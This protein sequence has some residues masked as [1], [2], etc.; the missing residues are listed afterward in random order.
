VRIS[1]PALILRWAAAL[2]GA[3]YVA[4]VLVRWHELVTNNN[5][6]T[7]AV[8]KMVVAER[9]RGSGP[10][11][12]PHYGEWTTLWWMLATR[13]LSW[14]H[15][16]WAVSGYAWILAGAAVLA[17]ATWR[18]A[19]AWAGLTAAAAM[20]VVGPFAI[21]SYIA[22]TGAHTTSTVA[23]IVLGALYSCAR[24]A[25]C[26]RLPG[27][28]SPACARRRTRSSGSAAFCRSRLPLRCSGG[29]GRSPFERAPS[30]SRLSSPEW[31][32]TR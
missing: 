22:T 16:L 6:D 24:R 23:A 5:W 20:L 4:Y 9:L 17:W 30:S 2:A 28:C 12:I 15:D 26:L 29:K 7:D 10:V 14:H 21:R 27:A 18:V 1:R 8:A 19:G 3:A 32:R 25:C 13:W 31:S 11:F